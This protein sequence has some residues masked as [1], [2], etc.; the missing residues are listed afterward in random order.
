MHLVFDLDGVLL[1]SESDLSW[2]DR[3][4]DAAIAELDLPDNDAVRGALYPPTVEGFHALADRYGHDPDRL[5][6]VR[7]D[8]YVREKLAA[9]ESGELQ[10]FDDVPVIGEL[11]AEYDRHI[12]SNSPA[13]VVT[14]F[15]AMYD[16]E[17]WFD[18]RLGRDE[19]FA[20]VSRLKPDPYLYERLD[21]Q[22]TDRRTRVYIGDTESDRA[23]AEATGMRFVHLTRDSSGVDSLEALPTLLERIESERND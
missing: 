4:L 21:D 16:Y 6:T 12:L 7:N 11:P 9:I 14:S 3:A 10:P 23:F 13:V 15:V 17:D 18:I 5:W 8:H 22:L 1:D 19:E 2:L 20:S